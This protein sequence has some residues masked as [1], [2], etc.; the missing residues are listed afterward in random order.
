VTPHTGVVSPSSSTDPRPTFL[1]RQDESDDAAFY[2]DPVTTRRTPDPRT[3][4]RGDPLFAVVA[5][6][7]PDDAPTL[8]G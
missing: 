4:Y 1:R 5:T 8:A 7:R 2:R 3:G 6:R